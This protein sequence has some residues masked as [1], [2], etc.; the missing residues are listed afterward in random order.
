[1]SLNV[2]A[3]FSTEVEEAQGVASEFCKFFLGGNK[4]LFVL[5]CFLVS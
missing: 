3:L 1:M 2:Q 5:F 4:S